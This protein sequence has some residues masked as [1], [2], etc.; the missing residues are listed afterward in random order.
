MNV[1]QMTSATVINRPLKDF[2]CMSDS[3]DAGLMEVAKVML[4]NFVFMFLMSSGIGFTGF[5]LGLFRAQS[6]IFSFTVAFSAAWGLV[7]AGA[8]WS[9][10]NENVK[11]PPSLRLLLD[12]IG[13]TDETAIKAAFVERSIRQR[14]YKRLF[15]PFVTYPK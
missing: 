12:R 9:R 15:V 8:A 3:Q 4:E 2:M 13:V 1:I 11:I 6:D 5:S 10:L 7:A 14:L